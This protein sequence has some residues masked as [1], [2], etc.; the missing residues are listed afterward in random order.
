MKELSLKVS[1]PANTAVS[2]FRRRVCRFYRQLMT[3]GAQAAGFQVKGLEYTAAGKT[4]SAEYNNIKG[5]SH[6][7]FTGFAP[8]EDPEV[9]V[10]IIVEGAGS[11]GDYAAPI[12]K[13]VFLMRTSAKNSNWRVKE[14][15]RSRLSAAAES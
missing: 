12:A 2:M 13:Y 1:N 4:G 8:A 6:A 9:C 3:D 15:H 11:G 7:W 14:K 5:D 10:T